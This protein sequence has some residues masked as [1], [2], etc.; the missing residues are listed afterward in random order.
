MKFKVRIM[1]KL[2]QYGIRFYVVTDAETTYVL[3]S[4][5]YT[6]KDTV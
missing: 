5:F 1:A 6:W 3:K 4:I 2:V